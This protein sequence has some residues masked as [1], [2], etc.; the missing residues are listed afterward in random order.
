LEEGDGLPRLLIGEEGRFAGIT[1][2]SSVVIKTS[3][4]FEKQIKYLMQCR[5]FEK[6]KNF[7][8]H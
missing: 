3:F 2:C 8:G 6:K 5:Q 1:F 7:I 4:F